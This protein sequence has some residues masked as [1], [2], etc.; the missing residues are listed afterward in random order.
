MAAIFLAAMPWEANG[1]L[2]TVFTK[3]G[4]PNRQ[5]AYGSWFWGGSNAG[6]DDGREAVA[7]IRERPKEAGGRREPEQQ[8]PTGVKHEG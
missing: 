6:R 1:I 8:L 7:G 4:G 5:D 3:C 2:F